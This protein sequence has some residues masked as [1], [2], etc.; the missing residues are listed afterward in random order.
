MRS[1]CQSQGAILTFIYFF[2]FISF[3][4]IF[5]SFYWYFFLCLCQNGIFSNF[6]L[7]YFP[8]FG[9]NYFSLCIF[10]PRFVYCNCG[11]DWFYRGLVIVG[12]IKNDLIGFC[13][14]ILLNLVKVFYYFIFIIKNFFNN[15]EPRLRIV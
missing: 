1:A 2:R 13:I 9:V 5:F 14:N 6:S 3:L 15:I 11:L 12:I 7:L 8:S 4:P 10:L